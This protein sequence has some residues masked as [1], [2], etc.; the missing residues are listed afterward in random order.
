MYVHYAMHSK[1]ALS[2]YMANMDYFKEREV[3]L[4]DKLGVTSLMLQ[5]IQWLPRYQ[6][7]LKQMVNAL[8]KIDDKAMDTRRDITAC[9][10]ALHY[11][12]RMLIRVNSSLSL[13]DFK[14]EDDEVGDMLLFLNIPYV[15]IIVF[16]LQVASTK[17]RLL[18][19]G[20][21]AGGTTH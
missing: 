14:V 9:S 15:Q 21:R 16:S 12:E 19:L 11:L 6:L 3:Q 20:P 18:S 8:N 7:L 5:P 2:V 4:G 17:S 1:R 10:E 13:N